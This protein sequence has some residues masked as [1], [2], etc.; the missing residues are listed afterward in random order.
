MKPNRVSPSTALTLLLTTLLAGLG[1]AATKPAPK[2]APKAAVPAPAPAPEAP[3]THTVARGS[4][5][6]KA[7]L[8]AVF[9]AAEMTPIKLEPKAWM[10]LTVVEAVPHGTRVR[11]GDTLVK[12]D[13]EKLKD[14]IEDLEKEKPLA[15]LALETAVAELDNLEQTTPQRLEASKRAAR[16]ADEEWTYFE[17]TG[18][19]QREKNT[20]F[21]L[22][23][24]EERLAYALEELKQ[25]EKMY[26]ADDLVETTEEIILRR[27]KFTVESAQL[28]LDSTRLG[29]ERDLKVLI[30]REAETLKAARRDTELAL[31]LAE[32]TL[33]KALAKKRLEVEKLKRDQKKTEKRLADLKSDWEGLSVRA[34][35]AGIVY[36]GACENGKWPTGPVVAKKLAPGMKLQPNEILMTIVNPEKLQLK[37][38]IA[39][40]DL[41]KFK[42]GMTGQ[43]APVAAPDRKLA[44]KLEEIGGIPA[45]AGG[46][47]ATLAL[48]E[49]KPAGVVPGMNAKVTLSDGARPEVPLAPCQAVFGEGAQRYV[50]RVGAGGQPEKRA[51]KTG[52]T[53]NKEIEILEGLAE[54][55]KILLKEPGK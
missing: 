19:A 49:G 35:A 37:G 24:A 12:L 2:A 53:D 13:L 11:K 18:R 38:M 47:E 3:P 54:G 6:P 34:P 8:D 20:R 14:Q 44:V 41:A 1:C 5:K 27:Q 33:P 30:P 9:V 25:L 48:T 4:L 43:A 42:A 50:W 40:G 7:Q 55:D 10:D 28:A 16:I 45:V 15:A 31:A 17:K 32:E 29:T 22:K 21:N 36:Y 26:Q 52:E 51:V 39:E 23:N 46:F